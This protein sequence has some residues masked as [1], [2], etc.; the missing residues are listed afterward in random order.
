MTRHKVIWFAAFTTAYVFFAFCLRFSPSSRDPGSAFFDPVRAYN[1]VY[2]KTRENQATSFLADVNAHNVTIPN[3]SSTSSPSLCIAIATVARPDTQYVHLTVGS[4]FEGLTPLERA[5]IHFIFFI[6]HTDPKVHPFYDEPWT[7][8]LPDTV[9][10]YTS[11]N[12]SM[13]EQIATWEKEHNYRMKGLFDYNYLLQACQDHTSAPFVSLIEGDVIAARGWLL[14]AL[15]AAEYVDS[16]ARPE[17]A[18]L[19]GNGKQYASPWLYLRLFYTE[20]YLGW[21]S[22]EWPTY[23]FSSVLV[24]VLI[25]GTLLLL[26]SRN[27]K[28]A[29]H[30]S[31]TTLLILT[32]FIIPSLIAL[33]FAAGRSTMQPFPAGVRRMENFGCC[34]QGFIF[35]RKILP[36]IMERVNKRTEGFID[37]LMEGF[38]AESKL[39]RWTVVPSLLQH[40]GSKSSKGDPIADERAKMIWNFGF[41]RYDPERGV[42]ELP[43]RNSGWRGWVGSDY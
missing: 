32:F 5:S 30:L 1:K 21:N 31:N 12:V 41:E 26:R 24:T 33:Y 42:E 15:S 27:K 19:D 43:L 34:S 25:I 7:T 8:S 9:L 3:T 39:E 14:R 23:L 18:P 4:L 37:M 13:Q 10:T 20:T 11:L 36:A 28:F 29:T 16:L 17:G 38:A 2:S 35:P 40:I 22:E 6:A